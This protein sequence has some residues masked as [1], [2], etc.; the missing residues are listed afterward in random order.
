MNSLHVLEVAKRLDATGGGARADRHEELRLLAH[1]LDAL[2]VVRRGDRAFDQGDVVRAL[3]DGARGLGEIGDL[4]RAGH[5][6]QFVLAVEQAQL[7]AVARR[8]LPNG[9][10]GL[11]MLVADCVFVLLISPCSYSIGYTQ[12]EV[13]SRHSSRFPKS[14]DANR[15]TGRPCR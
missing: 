15:K 5:G 13:I 3:D 8:E 2:G 7:A 11:S 10:L 9:Q 4:D 12:I 14:A 1:L 6:Q